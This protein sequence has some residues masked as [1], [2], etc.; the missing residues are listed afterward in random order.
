MASGFTDVFSDNDIINKFLDK[1]GYEVDNRKNKGSFLEQH[2][3]E[4][5]NRG[6]TDY[7]LGQGKENLNFG[8]IT[9]RYFKGEFDSE[10]GDIKSFWKSMKDKGIYPDKLWNKGFD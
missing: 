5:L 2:G 9:K 1:F 8:N 3:A 6:L 4:V 10:D 7:D